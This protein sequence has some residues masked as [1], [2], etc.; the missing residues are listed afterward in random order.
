M[1]G[2]I[3]GGDFK[4][5]AV[6]CNGSV[7]MNRVIG[8]VNGKRT[9]VDN[10]VRSCFDAF[11]AGAVIRC[12]RSCIFFE[13]T[14]ASCGVVTLWHVTLRHV[15][16]RHI[17]LWFVTLIFF[18]LE[19]VTLRS[20]VSRKISPGIGGFGGCIGTAATGCNQKGAVLNLHIGCGTDTVT[21]GGNIK[22]AALDINKSGSS[23]I[24]IFGM[25]AVFTGNNG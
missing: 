23:I 14:K 5:A 4:Y 9:T 6:D 18:T 22:C 16:L 17:H 11:D 10:K 7:G 12:F 20:A 24:V 21:F 19:S 3:T 1:E 2:V 15:T 8:R 13:C 25:D